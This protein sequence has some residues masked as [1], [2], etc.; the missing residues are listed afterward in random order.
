MIGSYLF[1]FA[2]ALYSSSKFSQCSI[3]SSGSSPKTSIAYMPG[4][5]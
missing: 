3:A 1:C 2:F 5:N 4:S